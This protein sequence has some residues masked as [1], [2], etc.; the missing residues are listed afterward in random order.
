M[1]RSTA[2]V[3]CTLAVL[4]LYVGVL[5]NEGFRSN[6]EVFPFFKWELFSQV[7]PQIN[8]SYSARILEIDG[9]ALAEPLYFEE[10]REYQ[11]N[12]QSP[13]AQLVLQRFGQAMDRGEILRTA[14]Q[15]ELFEDRWLEADKTVRYELVKREFDVLERISCDCY[16][17]EEVMG[18]FVTD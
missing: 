13:E 11:R 12:A 6:T 1:R 17:S 14:N 5:W 7:P 8:T 3:L 18:V 4:V 9:E 15:Q 2:R 10:A 16:I